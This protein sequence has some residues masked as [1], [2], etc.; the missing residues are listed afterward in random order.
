MILFLL[1][2]YSFTTYGMNTKI[3]CST[4]RGYNDLIINYLQEKESSFSD[5]QTKYTAIKNKMFILKKKY[6]K[7]QISSIARDKKLE[8]LEAHV[9]DL[10]NQSD[11]FFLVHEQLVAKN[12]TLQNGNY[13]L[14]NEIQRKD[15]TI[16]QL[17]Q[18]INFLKITQDALHRKVNK[19]LYQPHSL[20]EKQIK[21]YNEF[22]DLHNMLNWYKDEN[23]RQTILNQ[24]LEEKNAQLVISLNQSIACRK[25]IERYCKEEEIKKNRSLD[26]VKK[27]KSFIHA[28]SRK[29][30]SKNNEQSKIFSKWLMPLVRE[31]VHRSSII[32]SGEFYLCMKSFGN[33]LKQFKNI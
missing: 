3:V 11:R 20:N 14:Q 28:M 27:F 8:D 33:E 30:F 16:N 29:L 24:K 32:Q 18:H 9:K 12:N 23:V 26:D 10:R 21:E 17:C 2:F 6:A 13:M 31:G 4:N 7:D 19:V 25:K 22:V 1:F 5:E 15:E